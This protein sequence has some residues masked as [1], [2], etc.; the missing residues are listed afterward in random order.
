MAEPAPAPL[1]LVDAD[2][3]DQ[4]YKEAV[5]VAVKKCADDTKGQTCPIC[6]E[7]IHSETQEGL[8]RMCA[9][10]GTAGFAHV[11]C[12][13]EQAKI[14][15]SEVE[16]NN[17]GYK[18]FNERFKRWQACSLCEQ[19]YHGIVRC[20]LGWACWKTYVGRPEAGGVRIAAMSSLG[21]GL[22]E[23]NNNESA[24]PVMEAELAARRRLGDTERNILCVQ[25]NLAITY[26]MMG[27]L[28]RA[29]QMKRDVYS[30]YL[31]LSGEEDELT[32][33]AASNLASLLKRLNHFEEAKSLLHKTVPVARRVL[34]E[35][36]ELTL[37]MR[38]NYAGA[39]YRDAD[40]T[41][42]DLREAVETLAETDRIARRVLGGAH[43]L[44]KF[45]QNDL[46]NVRAALAASEAPPT[47]N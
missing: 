32:L 34:G 4:R 37:R 11:S 39:L 42:D 27:Q 45:L 12:L 14:L 33:V 46:R 30:G 47:S 31:D 36:Y 5:A 24:L 2:L 35:S 13:A 23:A 15:L 40:A 44:T 38:M 22:C 6:W 10:R 9:C 18:V 3:V 25:G 1:W 16:E 21:T 7:S 29:Q 28:D 20:A 17:L 41:L 19:K 43:P 26:E 8:V